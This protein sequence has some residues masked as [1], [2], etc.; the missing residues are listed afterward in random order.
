MISLNNPQVAI[1]W[2]RSPEA[3]RERCG[4]V[5]A[6]A[7]RDE[8]AHFE[9]AI[10]RL[11]AVADYVIE[12]LRAA[13][14]N[15]NIPFHSRW[16]HFAAGGIDR[17]ARLNAKL[18][19]T[20][21]DEI[22]RIRMELAITSVLLDAGAGPAWRYREPESDAEF[23]RSEG[24][25]VASFHL[26]AR[27]AFS[28]AL[29]QP[30]R[31]DAIG[32]AMFA[33]ETLA[34]AFQVSDANPLLGLDERIELL[35][36]LGT[37]IQS[38]PGVFGKPA[39]LGHLF[40]YLAALADNKQLPAATILMTVLDALGPIWPGRIELEGINLGDVWRHPIAA[41]DDLTSE[42]I[43]FHKLSLWLSYSLIEPLEAAGIQVVELDTLAGLAE[44]RNG[45]LFID[46]GVLRP[47]REE[48]LKARF[49]VDSEVIVEWRALTVILL[50][51]LA[52]RIRE[53][54]GLDHESLPL[55]KVLEGGSWSAGRRVARERRPD[56]SPPI[57]LD[58][59]GTVF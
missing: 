9:L 2:L 4:A 20:S 39:R 14:P 33:H 44:Y 3:I 7:E 29:D 22:A 10:E 13:Y 18:A 52:E 55:A 45:G 19:D 46:L 5:F 42:L 34:A 12:T 21:P 36:R 53:K 59:D 47:K 50:D 16:R 15:L 30:L 1:A 23:S 58:S 35:R 31:V 25:A 17:W 11:D 6:A 41:T 24:L 43:P 27:G 26:Y 32:L 40:D 54:L 48:I 8:L 37:A 56:G 28:A 57:H 49:P 38:L 51:L